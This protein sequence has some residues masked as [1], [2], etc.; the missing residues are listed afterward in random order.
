MKIDASNRQ[1]LL[2]IVTGV[3]VGLFLLDRIVITPLL[4]LWKAHATEIAKLKQSVANGR[5]T[6]ANDANI[7]R[8]W[9]DMQNHALPK[10]A[11]T[12][13][14]EVLSALTNW[15]RANNVDLNYRQQRKRGPNNQTSLLEFRVDATGTMTTLARFLHE[16]ERSP[17]A[18][19]ID[20]AELS[21]RDE[22]GQ[23]LTLALIITG[24]RFAP[25]E[26]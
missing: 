24:L 2:I 25:L 20:S 4:G 11:A 10:D 14:Q 5:G 26:R 12:A 8:V 15:G 21:S 1:R 18:L 9:Q 6:I 7:R 23:R 16:L 13:D 17:M 22:S 19:R 3:A